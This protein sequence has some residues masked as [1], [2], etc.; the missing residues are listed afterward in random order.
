VRA[1]GEGVKHWFQMAID[2]DTHAGNSEFS[3]DGG[4]TF[5]QDDRSL[6]LRV[7]TGRRQSCRSLRPFR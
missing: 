3:T 1:E 2:T 4:K 6:D 7:Q 5:T